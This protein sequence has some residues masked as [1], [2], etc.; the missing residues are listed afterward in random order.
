MFHWASPLPIPT[1]LAAL[2]E[3]AG[4]SCCGPQGSPDLRVF[5]PPHLLLAAGIGGNA[6]LSQA[7]AGLAEEDGSERLINGERLLGMRPAEIAHWL[8]TNSPPERPLDLAAVDPLLATVTLALLEQQP[9]LVEEYERLDASS[10]RGGAAAEMDYCR[11]LRPPA[12]DLLTAWQELHGLL[13][14][15]EAGELQQARQQLH[16]LT[17]TLERQVIETQ[18]W[19]ESAAQRQRTNR[20]LLSDMQRLRLLIRRLMGLQGRLLGVPSAPRISS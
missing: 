8:L 7:Y 9:Q 15:Q 5:L 6:P 10:T 4:V 3:R 17:D 16:A 2:L 14:R 12:A 13:E 1:A 19:R 18:R 11:R 20:R